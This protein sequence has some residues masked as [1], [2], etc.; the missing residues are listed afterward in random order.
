MPC[1]RLGHWPYTE[2]QFCPKMSFLYHS[3]FVTCFCQWS[4][5]YRIAWDGFSCFYYSW[6]IIRGAEFG[7]PGDYRAVVGS[8]TQL[9]THQLLAHCPLQQMGERIRRGKKNNLGAWNEDRKVMQRQTLTTSHQQSGAQQV[10]EQWLFCKHFPSAVAEHDVLWHRAPLDQRGSP[11]SSVSPPSLLPTPS[12][13]AE[14]TDWGTGLWKLCEHCLAIAEPW[15]WYQHCF[16][17]KSKAR[18]HMGC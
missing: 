16:S 8:V 14:G 5:W 11:V 1:W 9:S 4:V 18:H 12:P 7:A 15:V 17:H 10:S 3:S 13:L 6:N 2:L